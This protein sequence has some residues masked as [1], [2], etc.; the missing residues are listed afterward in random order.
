[1]GYVYPTAEKLEGLLNI[2]VWSA[3]AT[4]IFYSLGPS[5]GGLITLAS[6]NKFSNNCHRDA[7]LIAYPEAVTQMPVPQLWSFLFFF[8]L[9]TLGLDSQFTMTETITTAVMDQWPHLLLPGELHLPSV[10]A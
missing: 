9:I 7:M 8:M 4:Q 5:F 10:G 6:Y 1:M 3:A 2:N